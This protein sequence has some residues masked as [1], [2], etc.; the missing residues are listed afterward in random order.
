MRT[1]GAK[2]SRVLLLASCMVA[3]NGALRLPDDPATPIVSAPPEPTGT[4]PIDTGAW[5][6]TPAACDD[7]AE[8]NDRVARASSYEPGDYQVIDSS[9]DVWAITLPPETYL[10]LEIFGATDGLRTRMHEADDTE[11]GEAY[12]REPVLDGQQRLHTV[13]NP[14][15]GERTVY[16]T[17]VGLNATCTG[18]RLSG[19]VRPLPDCSPDPYE[20]NDFFETSLPYPEGVTE[21]AVTNTNWADFFRLPF[22][23]PPH[24]SV[25]VSITFDHD[26]GDLHLYAY[27]PN[28]QQL[29]GDGRSTTETDDEHI[30][31]LNFTE[32][33]QVFTIHP[34]LANVDTAAPCIPYTVSIGTPV[35][36][37]P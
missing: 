30:T 26:L 11:A 5:V 31:I 21:F 13:A 8:P 34:R 35:A 6:P 32:Q 14:G 15:P 24:H 17:V 19:E 20:P 33:E 16:V 18:Y 28:D 22:P 23:L 4:Q 37:P 10:G 7:A 2:T 3:C 29:I 1:P 36:V 25:D 27:W 9:P 12:L